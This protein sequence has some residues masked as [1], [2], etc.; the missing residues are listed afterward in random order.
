MEIRIVIKKEAE[1]FCAVMEG[2]KGV[3]LSGYGDTA[4]EALLEIS[5]AL[6]R[7]LEI[8]IEDGEDLWQRKEEK[9]KIGS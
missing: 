7:V 3:N 8:M 1:E 4:A 5:H 2:V 6:Q 9:K